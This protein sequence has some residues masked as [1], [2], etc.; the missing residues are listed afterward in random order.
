MIIFFIQ[1]AIRF[2]KKCISEIHDIQNLDLV[3]KRCLQISV[4]WKINS[5]ND[6]SKHELVL[7]VYDVAVKTHG[8]VVFK[9]SFLMKYE[10]LLLP[11]FFL[12]F[13]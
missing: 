5:L 4:M 10:R 1:K 13:F 11:V 3:N 2:L 8:K 9:L 7:H 12:S 6:S